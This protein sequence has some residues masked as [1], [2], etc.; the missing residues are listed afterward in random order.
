M[1]KLSALREL[2]AVAETVAGTF[3]SNIDSTPGEH[4]K[5]KVFDPVFE[6]DVQVFERNFSRNNLSPEGVITTTKMG[7]I[8]FSLEV[9]RTNASDTPDEWAAVLLPACGFRENLSSSTSC[10][11]TPSSDEDDWHTLT[12][13]VNVD[14][15]VQYIHG[16]MG[17]V[18]FRGQIGEVM[19]M[20]FEFMGLW[21][22]DNAA[23]DPLN[24][25]I[26]HE[27]GVPL[28]F[29]GIAFDYGGDTSHCIASVS[30]NMGNEVVMHECANNV[31]GYKQATI[32]R[33][34]PELTVNPELL[35]L[36]SQDWWSAL[37]DNTQESITFDNGESGDI[38]FNMPKAQLQ[39]SPTD[40]D[41]NGVAALSLTFVLCS[42]DDDGDDELV[43]TMT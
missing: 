25:N 9:R 24:T 36:A 38:D 31:T 29:Q 37:A 23:D 15:V 5:F 26:S 1:P 21:D 2:R 4:S 22:E 10:I 33:R 7:K 42:D 34:K 6:A 16:A 30:L 39:T 35:S 3:Q 40:E 18:T 27:A 11:Y 8:T 17:N 32:V 13:G 19:M 43:I 12:M 14:G 41:R 28:P 20:D